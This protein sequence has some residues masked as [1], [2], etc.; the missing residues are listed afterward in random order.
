MANVDPPPYGP[1]QAPRTLQD[2]FDDHRAALV[3]A[4]W[5]LG[6]ASGANYSSERE[7]A[8][9]GPAIEAIKEALR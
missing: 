8:V 1:A 9:Y 3:E 4:L 7:Q 5:A 2:T 6:Y